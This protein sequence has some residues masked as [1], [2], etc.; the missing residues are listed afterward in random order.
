[1]IVRKIILHK[2]TTEM[3]LMIKN[4]NSD[5]TINVIM[6]KVTIISI[7]I[8]ILIA[9]I[10]FIKVFQYIHRGQVKQRS[11]FTQHMP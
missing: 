5:K 4:G 9:I 8:I 2:V 1:M 7:T 11:Y 6:L 10:Q 3:I